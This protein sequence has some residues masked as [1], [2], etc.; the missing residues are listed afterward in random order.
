[1]TQELKLLTYNLLYK[2]SR[3]NIFSERLARDLGDIGGAD[4]MAFQELCQNTKDMLLQNKPE[5]KYAKIIRCQEGSN[6]IMTIMNP[7][8][9]LKAVCWNSFETPRLDSSGNKMIDSKGKVVMD[10]GRPFQILV[11]QYMGDNLLIL[12]CHFPHIKKKDLEEVIVKKLTT[13]LTFGVEIPKKLPD[14]TILKPNSPLNLDFTRDNKVIPKKNI[15]HLIIDKKF[16]VI[17]MGDFNDNKQLALINGFKPFNT[18]YSPFFKKLKAE[19]IKEINKIKLGG[20]H[21]SAVPKSCCLSY[22]NGNFKGQ[23]HR[24]GDY[25]MVD[26]SIEIKVGNHVPDEIEKSLD[27]VTS[28]HLP[29]VMKINFNSSASS[30]SSSNTSE[31]SVKKKFLCHP[32]LFIAP[33]E[34]TG[35]GTETVSRSSIKKKKS[36]KKKRN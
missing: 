8:I 6:H 30:K 35:T 23:Y 16:K 25:I 32:K 28:D 19:D 31:N 34:G 9:E 33:Q 22:Q 7:E 24:Q 11:C 13:N 29:V 21:I 14:G 10:R 3:K 1:M 20:Q 4:I 15:T 5:L 12:N 17:M 2:V 26:K 27:E 36:K 18:K